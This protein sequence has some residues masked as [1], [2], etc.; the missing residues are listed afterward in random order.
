MMHGWR[1]PED[2]C[3]WCYSIKS[4]PVGEVDRP[5]PSFSAVSLQMELADDVD[6]EVDDVGEA[7]ISDG[8]RWVDDQSNVQIARAR[9]SHAGSTLSKWLYEHVLLLR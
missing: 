2:T 1:R 5:N 3:I 9:Y 4:L 6:D 8:S 7:L